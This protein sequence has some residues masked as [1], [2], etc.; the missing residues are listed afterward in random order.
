MKTKF[1]CL[2]LI[3]LLPCLMFAQDVLHL[4]DGKKI[5]CKVVAINPE[6]VE[7]S[8]GSDMPKRTIAKED[9]S[10]IV[11]EN[12]EVETFSNSDKPENQYQMIELERR[13]AESEKKSK[14]NENTLQVIGICCVLLVILALIPVPVQ[15]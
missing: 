13:L 14:G 2:I 4:K 6:T 1:I 10:V 3:I 9:I 7:V 15:E 8:T 5:K 12:G 11:Y